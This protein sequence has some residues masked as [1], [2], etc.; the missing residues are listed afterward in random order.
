MSKH[1][2]EPN[3][4]I[5]RSTLIVLIAACAIVG[6]LLFAFLRIRA[7]LKP[8]R[9]EHD[10]ISIDELNRLD[11]DEDYYC[12]QQNNREDP[13][14]VMTVVVFGDDTFAYDRGPDGL[15]AMIAER[16][17]ATVYNCAFEGSS[18][19]CDSA[20]LDWE[21]HP[22]DC[23]SPYRLLIALRDRYF[24][25]YDVAY[26]YMD[27]VPDYF[28]DTV[29]LIQSIDFDTVDVILLQ[30][31]IHDYLA[32]HTNTDI[33][34][35]AESDVSTVHSAI[36]QSVQL[37]RDLFPH[38]QIVVSSPCFGYYTL[39]DGS[40]VSGDLVRTGS[41]ISDNLPGYWGNIKATAAGLD[42]T[43]IDNYCGYN[44]N[45]DNAAQYM[46]AGSPIVP[47]VEGRKIMADHIADVLLHHLY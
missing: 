39:E 17:N 28:R 40:L 9:V 16:T 6:I 25:V 33:L 26:S 13:D 18:Y 20:V 3:R 10:D 24:D 14:E 29:S 31:G 47:N 44:V 37:I 41:E 32:G 45:M 15:A 19:A 42:V 11:Y 8:H 22:M 30:Y 35:T 46:T 23:F 7:F 36:V 5:L 1:I 34:D 38:V 43:F 2:D 21:N 4:K 12:I 27:T